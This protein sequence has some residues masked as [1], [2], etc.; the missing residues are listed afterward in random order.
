MKQTAQGALRSKAMW[1]AALVVSLGVFE[2]KY[3]EI[4]QQYVPPK[5]QALV[6]MLIGAAIA[7]V[8]VFTSQSL[9]DKVSGPDDT[10]EHSGV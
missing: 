8:R 2:T 7:I 6:L 9:A 4:V 3:A 5:H 1:L 10:D